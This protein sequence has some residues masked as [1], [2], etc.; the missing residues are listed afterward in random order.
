MGGN[1][2]LANRYLA[3][4]VTE[5]TVYA[6]FKG[7]QFATLTEYMNDACEVVYVWR[8]DWDA[9]D[10]INDLNCFIMGIDLDL[11]KE[12][13]VRDHVPSF[14]YSTIPPEGRED[15]PEILERLGLREYDALD[16]LIACGKCRRDRIEITGEIMY[17][18]N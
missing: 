10:R 12:E 15:I 18:V 6:S 3:G 11:R 4:T 5:R 13:Y 9:Y 1:V 17:P 7:T 8:V 2:K 16:I 14:I